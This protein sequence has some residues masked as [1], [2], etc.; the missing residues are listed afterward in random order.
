MIVDGEIVTDDTL[1]VWTGTVTM[2]DALID[3]ST[4]VTVMT[5]LPDDKDVTKPVEDTEQIDGFELAHVTALFEAFVGKMVTFNCDVCRIWSVNE[6]GETLTLL[7]FC[8][9]SSSTSKAFC[10]AMFA[11]FSRCMARYIFAA[12]R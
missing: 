3:P 2:L 1:I 7:T 10:A 11:S 9:N 12:S 8:R 4:D 6:V 5:E